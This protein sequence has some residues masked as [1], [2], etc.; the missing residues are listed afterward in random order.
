M[1]STQIPQ[2]VWYPCD[3][4]AQLA[5]VT[6]EW[7]YAEIRKGNPDIKV[8]RRGAKLTIHRSF[9][10]GDEPTMLMVHPHAQIDVKEEVEYAIA[11]WLEELN[12]YQ[13]W[14]RGKAA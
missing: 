6:R 14:R 3:E 13:A 12:A 11:R 1:T 2:R 4:A 9:I 10:F 5:G 8:K 7:L